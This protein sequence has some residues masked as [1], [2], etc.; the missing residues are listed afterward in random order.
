M[1]EDLTVL[2]S[3]AS[4]SS[5]SAATA[6]TTP[7]S[8]LWFSHFP[9]S[10]IVADH[11]A[12][13]QLMSTSVAHICGHLH[14]LNGHADTMYARHPSGHLELELVDFKDHRM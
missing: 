14:D 4:S 10:T 5:P 9:T 11:R 1:Q 13:R 12:L 7:N 8:T 2:R 3:L 6:P